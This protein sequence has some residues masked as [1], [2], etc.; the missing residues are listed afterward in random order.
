M[1]GDRALPQQIPVI[2]R[3]AEGMDHRRQ[4]QRRIRRPPGDHDIGAAV[5]SLGDRLRAEIGIGRQQPV[6]ELFD[7]SL[8]FH[9]GEVTI[10][11][12]LEHVVADDGGNP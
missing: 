5:Q 1:P 2:H 12:G 3:P 6:A 11:A 8:E 9:N 7:R 10:L 4:K